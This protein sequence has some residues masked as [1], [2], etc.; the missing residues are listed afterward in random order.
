MTNEELKRLA[1]LLSDFATS[2]YGDG[3]NAPTEV[4]EVRKL[5]DE[6]IKEE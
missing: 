3:D 6:Q 4:E 2:Y 5:V 1:Y